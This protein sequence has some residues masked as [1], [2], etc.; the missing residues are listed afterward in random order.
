ME[1]II[2]FTAAR[3]ES[4]LNRF[5]R[6][7]RIPSV[8]LDG[9]Y[10]I[11]DVED[12]FAGLS[13]K[14]QRIATKFIE[15]FKE[16]I[17]SNSIQLSENFLREYSSFIRDQRTRDDGWAFPAVMS[18]FRSNIN[19]VR[20]LIYDAREVVKSYTS[21]NPRHIWLHAILTENEFHNRLL[22]AIIT[23]RK[24][25]DKILNAYSPLYNGADLQEPLQ[26][27]HLRRLRTDLLEYANTITKLKQWDP[28]E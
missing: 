17:A 25:V 28:E 7:K 27:I 2:N 13:K 22:D 12:V 8:F 1:E 16:N 14:H 5:Q 24:R 23:D 4:E 19:P 3:I 20:A 9:T 18:R 10:T 26:M 21:E 11:A 6:N 15:H